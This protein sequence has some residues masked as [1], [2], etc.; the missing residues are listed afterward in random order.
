[1]AVAVVV[2]VE[3]G[4]AEKDAGTDALHVAVKSLVSSAA[5]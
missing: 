2:D 4:L 1:M 5:V 3:A